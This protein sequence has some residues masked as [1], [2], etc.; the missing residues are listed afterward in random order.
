MSNP[1]S[2][3]E[4]VHTLRKLGITD[5][6]WSTP[7]PVSDKGCKHERVYSAEGHNDKCV[8]CGASLVRGTWTPPPA[9]PALSEVA[10][11]GMT[12]T[13]VVV[14]NRIAWVLGLRS[15]GTGDTSSEEAGRIAEATAIL[16]AFAERVRAEAIEEC[17][18]VAASVPSMWIVPTEQWSIGFKAGHE[19]AAN[20]IR[21]LTRAGSGKGGV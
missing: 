7:A 3:D 17:A 2:F 10:N 11:P 14:V 8:D 15:E 4:A 21:S 5:G 19:S 20:A 18:K 16:A 12:D 9:D 1:K 6:G 13:P